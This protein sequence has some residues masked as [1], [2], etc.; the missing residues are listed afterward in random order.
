MATITFD[1]HA[2]IESLIK[3]GIKKPQAEA[4]VKGIQI[5]REFD[6]NN[7]AT[8]GD[9][10]DVKGDIADVKGEIAD[11]KGEIADVRTDMARMEKRLIIWQL[12]ITISSFSAMIYIIIEIIKVHLK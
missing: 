7:L 12:G 1:T 4:I 8:K 10:A 11:V 5:S 3:K 2:I 6:M 9:I